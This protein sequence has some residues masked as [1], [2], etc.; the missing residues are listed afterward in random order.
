ME[1]MSRLFIAEFNS[2]YGTQVVGLAP[3]V[4]DAFHKQTFRENVRQFKRLLEEL[5][6]TVK[7]GY[8]TLAE[9]APQLDRLSNENKE[10]SLKGYLEGTLEDIER[11]II[12]AVL[13][14]ENMNQSKA[15][16][17]LNINRTT[18]WRKLKE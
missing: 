17:R 8:I 16:K 10:E 7:S 14:E 4:M 9:A 13:Q 18:L 12:Q 15:A 1:D 2:A 6:L 5:V 3:E 11:R